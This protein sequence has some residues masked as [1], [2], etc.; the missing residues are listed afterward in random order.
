MSIFADWYAC[1]DRSF[2]G[3]GRHRRFER[4]LSGRGSRIDGKSKKVRSVLQLVSD[5]ALVFVG[6]CWCLLLS[7]QAV[8]MHGRY[9]EDT[10]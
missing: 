7:A 6:V 9:L 10:A 8:E 2:P 5:S 1:L 3:S 4:L